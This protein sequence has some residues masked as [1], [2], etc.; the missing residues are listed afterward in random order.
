MAV[1]QSVYKLYSF[2]MNSRAHDI[3]THELEKLDQ[4][5]KI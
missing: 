5:N 2:K 4:V 1:F 3:L